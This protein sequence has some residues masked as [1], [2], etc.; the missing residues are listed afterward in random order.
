M[1]ELQAVIDRRIEEN[2]GEGDPQ[3]KDEKYI[4]FKRSDFY[5]M[6]GFLGLPP[7][8]DQVT[9]DL[10][11]TTMDCAPLAQ[12]IIDEAER[13]CLKDAV[14]IRRQDYIAA[15]ALNS[16]AHLIGLA[17]TMNDDPSKAENLRA[18]ADYF[19][20]QA[21]LAAVEGWKWPD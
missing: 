5:M 21:E 13:T 10:V 7:W 2:G 3:V 18:V 1:D 15:P 14:V 20:Q 19:H 8:R 4:T 17:A 11:G 9:G 16:Y 12:S 6:M